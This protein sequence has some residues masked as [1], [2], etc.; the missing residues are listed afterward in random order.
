MIK[1]LTGMTLGL[2]L[3]AGCTWF[4]YESILYGD[5]LSRNGQQMRD[6]HSFLISRDSNNIKIDD[7]AL[8]DFCLNHKKMKALIHP[9]IEW[10]HNWTNFIAEKVAV[11]KAEW[12]LSFIPHGDKYL[13]QCKN[14]EHL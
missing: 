10:H 7:L 6:S 12:Y 2:M 1:T 4:Y 5:F 14:V 13:E 9:D 3:G 8:Y 11:K